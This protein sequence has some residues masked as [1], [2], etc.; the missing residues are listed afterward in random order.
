MGKVQKRRRKGTGEVQIVARKIPE[1][2]RKGKGTK[3]QESYRRTRK[4]QVMNRK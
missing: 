2:Y 3:A 1:R 4:V